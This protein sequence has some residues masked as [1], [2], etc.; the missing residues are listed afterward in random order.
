MG[1]LNVTPDSFSDGGR[2]SCP[3]AAVE[4]ALEMVAAG[5]DVIDIGG[6][7]TRPGA[8]EV[9]PKEELAR[10]LPVVRALRGQTG[11]L[12]SIDTRKS[13]VAAPC[14]DAG[15]DW[16]NDVSGLTFDAALAGVV[17][18]RTGARLVLMHSRARPADDR[19]STEY[20]ASAQPVYVDVVADTFKFLRR[21][22]LTAF[23]SGIPPGSLW[24]DPGFGFGK[25]SEQ[26]VELLRRLREY[27]SA[28]VPVLVGPSRKST[29]GR[30]LGD[31][32]PGERL[33]GTAAAVAWAVAQG[34]SCVRVHDV[35]EMARVVRVADAL[36][37]IS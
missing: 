8:A 27:T 26:N 4:G 10:V 17:A 34:A 30:L 7:S 29:V 13:A 37:A 3:S 35:R 16:I 28:G 24:F 23:Q 36:R 18:A 33:E 25:T 1:I 32:P 21:Q 12:L 11:A 9:P 31:L 22:A 6:E 2:W 14:L 15:A 19:Y 20:D 5:A